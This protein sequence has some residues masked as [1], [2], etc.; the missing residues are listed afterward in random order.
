MTY[1]PIVDLGTGTVVGVTAAVRWPDPAASGPPAHLCTWNVGLAS[2]LDRWSL[3]RALRDARTL[4]RAGAISVTCYVGVKISGATLLDP[5][6]EAFLE[7][8]RA[9]SGLSPQHVMLEIIRDDVTSRSD[10]LVRRFGVCEGA[11][12]S[13]RW[14]ASGTD[15]AT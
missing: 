6:G 11:A 1:E 13:W 8:S 4:R 12:T 10:L 2:A 15:T 3:E 7:E 9:T 5:G 14:P